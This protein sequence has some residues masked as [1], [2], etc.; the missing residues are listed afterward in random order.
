MFYFRN[1]G[2]QQK[3]LACDFKLIAVTE[4]ELLA[5]IEIK[6]LALNEVEFLENLADD[7]HKTSS[8]FKTYLYMLLESTNKS[9][10]CLR[11]GNSVYNLR[12]PLTIHR[13]CLQLQILRQC[14]LN[15][16]IIYY[17]IIDATNGFGFRK[18]FC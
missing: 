9:G 13:F 18:N 6:Q 14:S 16:H 3:S 11:F 5:V 15:I 10:F 8:F 4:F 1:T 7:P 17:L 2:N 12:I